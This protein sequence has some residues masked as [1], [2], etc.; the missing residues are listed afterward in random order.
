MSFQRNAPPDLGVPPYKGEGPTHV[1]PRPRARAK[2]PRLATRAGNQ[3]RI[4]NSNYASAFESNISG[5]G[6]DFP[7]V[8]R[9][10]KVRKGTKFQK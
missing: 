3:E 10:K 9:N 2:G 1:D 4:E 8:G 7:P 5:D 6:T